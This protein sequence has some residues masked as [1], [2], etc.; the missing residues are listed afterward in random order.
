MKTLLLVIDMQNDFC[1]P[2]GALYIAGSE[3][4]TSSVFEVAFALGWKSHSTLTLLV[5][6]D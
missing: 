4:V 1:K 5:K 3:E 6:Q 2:A